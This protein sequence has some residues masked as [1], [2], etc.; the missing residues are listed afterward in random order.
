MTAMTR[1]HPTT[2][3][4]SEGVP[5]EIEAGTLATLKVTVSCGRGC[6]LRHDRAQV[7]VHDA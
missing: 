3:H 2:V 1:A 5:P 7:L 4:V 6:D